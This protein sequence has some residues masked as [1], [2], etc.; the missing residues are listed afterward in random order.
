MQTHKT[1]KNPEKC[2]TNFS[3]LHCV[4]FCGLNELC[5]GENMIKFGGDKTLTLLST[6]YGIM[7]QGWE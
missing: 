5:E 1:S 3:N 4:P 2:L 6:V 7:E